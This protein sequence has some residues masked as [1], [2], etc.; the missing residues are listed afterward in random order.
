MAAMRAPVGSKTSICGEKFSLMRVNSRRRVSPEFA[1]C[2]NC[3][4]PIGNRCPTCNRILQADWKF[5][6]YC[7]KGA[8]LEAPKRASRR[9]ASRKLPELPA[10]SNVAEF[11]K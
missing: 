2:P 3:G 11:K 9:V 10:G 5:C 8:A 6:P 4:E 1:A 7:P